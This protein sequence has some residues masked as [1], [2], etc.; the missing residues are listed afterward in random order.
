MVG[1]GS[2]GELRVDRST[3]MVSHD[4]RLALA[5]TA[6]DCSTCELTFP[7]LSTKGQP[8]PRGRLLDSHLAWTLF[9]IATV[10]LEQAQNIAI[11]GQNG[12]L[13]LSQERLVKPRLART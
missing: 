10:W 5:K 6:L 8:C 9:A 13:T 4:S 11:E 2:R 7:S 12:R 1:L 3:Q